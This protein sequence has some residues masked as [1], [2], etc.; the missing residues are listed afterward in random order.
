VIINLNAL[1]LSIILLTV[2]FSLNSSRLMALWGVIIFQN[3]FVSIYPL[4]A[5]DHFS[6]GYVFFILFILVVKCVLIPTVIYFSIQKVSIKKEIDPFIGYNASLFVGLAII[7]ASLICSNYINGIYHLHQKFLLQTAITTMATGLFVIIARSKA[8]TMIIGYLILENGL[9]LFGSLV[10]AM[11]YVVEFGV[12]LDIFISIMLMWIIL[13]HINKDIED[14]DTVYLSN[15]K[16][17]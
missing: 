16:D 10:P 15:L 3:F 6:V 5:Q 13:Y 1:I 8:I 9:F 2:M 14:L 4:F 11:S 7:L 17:E 12:L